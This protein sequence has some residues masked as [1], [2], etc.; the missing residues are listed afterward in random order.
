MIYVSD[1]GHLSLTNSSISHSGRYGV[2]SE[3]GSASVQGC[4]VSDNGS[5]GVYLKTKADTPPPTLVNNVFNDNGGH[6]AVI[7]YDNGATAQISGNSGSGSTYGGIGME[8]TIDGTVTWGANSGLPYIVGHLDVA[9]GASLSISPGT[10]VK[11]RGQ[12]AQLDVGGTLTADADAGSP[13]VFTS[14]QDDAY[15]G[16]SNDDGGN[17]VPYKGAWETVRVLNGGSAA[18]NHVIV[19]Y[20]GDVDLESV[21]AMIYVSDGGHLSLTNSSISHSE[22]YGVHVM[23]RYHVIRDNEFYDN[24]SY[25]VYNGNIDEITVNAEHNWWGDVSGPDPYGS[26]DSINYRRCY[27]PGTGTYYV[28]EYYVDADPWIGKQ[29]QASGS[30]VD[31][32]LP[33]GRLRNTGAAEPGVPHIE[34]V[35]SAYGHVFLGNVDLDNPYTVIVDWNGADPDNGSPGKVVFAVN[36]R[37]VE[38]IGKVWGAKHTYNVG[39]EF[40]GGFNE[41]EIV[42]YNAAGVASRPMNLR[43][44]K[45]VLPGWLKELGIGGEIGGHGIKVTLQQDYLEFSIHHDIPEKPFDADLDVPGWF[46]YFGGDEIGAEAQGEVELNLRSD[47]TGDVGL[48]GKAEFKAAGQSIGGEVYG[49]GDARLTEQGGIQ[50]TQATFDFGLQ[51]TLE[52]EMPLVEFIPAVAAAAN[53]PVIGWA[54][55]PIIDILQIYAS[56]SPAV[57]FSA[58]WGPT[59]DGQSWEWK[60]GAGNTSLTNELGLKLD[61]TD[62]IQAKASGNGRGTLYFQVPRGQ[63]P[64]AESLKLEIWASAE[65]IAWDQDIFHGY[66]EHLAVTLSGE[67]RQTVETRASSFPIVNNTSVRVKDSHIVERTYGDQPYA[68]FVGDHASARS[69]RSSRASVR[70][71]QH[72]IMLNVYPQSR[73]ALA[74]QGDG[75]AVMVWV[76]DDVSLSILRSKEIMASRWDGTSWSTPVRVTQDTQSDYAPQIAFDGNGH[77]VAVW[78]RINDPALP[79]SATL[80]VTL[81][82][83]F[84]LAYSVYDVAG[85]NWS[86]ARHI[87]TNATFEHKP[88]LTTGNDGRIMLVW[89]SNPEGYLFGETAHPDTLYSAIWDGSAWS[90]PVVITDALTGALRST[91]AYADSTHAVLVVSRD[92]DG[93]WL[94]P[95]DVELFGTTWDGSAWSGFTQLTDDAVRDERPMAFY[96]SGGKKRLVWLKDE[97]LVLLHD[98]WSAMPVTT[99]IAGDVPG[100]KDFDVAMDVQDNLA[101]IW[102]G[103][104][105]ALTDMFY[106]LYDQATQTWNL[107][108]QLT[109]DQAI[110]NEMAPAFTADGELLVAYA[111][112]TMKYDDKVISPTLVITN[113]LQPD[114]TDLYILHYTPDTD[115]TLTDFSLPEY[116]DNPWPGN[117]VDVGVTVQNTGDWAVVSP[118]LA[119]YDGDPGAGGTLITLTHAISG[120]LAG[121]ASVDVTVRWTVPVTPVQPHTLYARLDPADAIDELDETNNVLTLTTAT[122]DLAVSSVKTYYYDQHNVVPLAIVANNGPVTATNV[123]VE[124]R[125]DAV[126]GTVQHSDVITT[127]APYGLKAITTTWDVSGWAEG[128]HPYYAV[129]DSTD[130]IF[131]VN[132]ND[133]AAVFPVKVWPDLVIYSGDVHADL[134]PSA[135]GPV[136]VTVRNWGT[137][138]ATDVPVTLYEGAVLTTGATALY[139]WTVTSLPV[140]SDGDMQLVTTLDHRPNRLFA[141]AD[142]GKVITEVTEHNNIAL[143]VQPISLTLRYHDLESLV[144]ATATVT[145]HT[146]WTT[147]TIPLAGGAADIYSV[148]VSTSA[149]P[150]HYRYTVDGDLGLLNSYTRTVT[151]TLATV[152]DDY[153]DVN[154]DDL[155]LVGPAALSTAVGAPTGPIT[156]QVTLADVT[157][158]AG[159]TF[160]AEI[161]YGTGITMT[162][163]TWTP[164]GYIGDEGDADRFAGTITPLSSGTYSYTVRFTGNWGAGNLNAG[165]QYADLNG[166]GDGFS[167]GQV[168]VLSVP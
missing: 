15:G 64:Y 123:L 62:N 145:L 127:L 99:G 14:L 86:K 35:D 46:P 55:K 92:V 41:I 10:V 51:G 66:T 109:H 126:T 98:D 27:D 80:D 67:Q 140:D 36:G 76:Y 143:A 120:P 58:A 72:P 106:A 43:A 141:I 30:I 3:Y 18:L 101:L 9:A 124:F 45:I 87:D 8:G 44:A 60:G 90:T 117:S 53:N 29:V 110:E 25:G 59:V 54:V 160:A 97:Q 147:D 1:G 88:L 34:S 113:A 111:R 89:I 112:Q 50:F 162:E 42:A 144:P 119:L 96:T 133:N 78:Q 21:S 115:L 130:A 23:S 121:G 167:L 77:A 131:E 74:V 164:I 75:T 114:Q 139:T 2:Q 48:G 32:A 149:T 100:L 134:D 6:G 108:A 135:G 17:S 73:P 38:E 153:R 91:L 65:F 152:Y 84:D 19:R 122:P 166:S 39:Q 104:S 5:D 150:L 13:I 40:V 161:G 52:A 154:A 118:T 7:E 93:D 49:Q 56:I 148:T 20:G 168:G 163:W 155:R 105:A 94:T 33:G 81:T 95:D 16:D 37:R 137:A 136:T 47:A 31:D 151:P 107:A 159:T 57:D 82:K 158:L 116:F 165:W 157:L 61:I 83:K 70:S 85:N 63:S 138:D 102:Q 142:P 103:P 12:H 4:T 71:T 129:V 28:C 128:D 132:E 24:D 11:F 125:Q 69:L 22:R 156:A 26:G 79:V 146:D 68:V